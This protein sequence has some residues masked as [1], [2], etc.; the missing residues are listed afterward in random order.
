MCSKK[1]HW[2]SP[3]L[4]H[5]RTISASMAVRSAMVL[6]LVY[7]ARRVCPCLFTRST[8]SIII[9]FFAFFCWPKRA[10]TNGMNHEYTAMP[11]IAKKI[12]KRHSSLGFRPSTTP[13]SDNNGLIIL[14]SP[15][16][17]AATDD[18]T[19]QVTLNIPASPLRSP[20]PI[21]VWKKRKQVTYSPTKAIY[22]PPTTPLSKVGMSFLSESAE[23][24]KRALTNPNYVTEQD[25]TPML[26]NHSLEVWPAN[27]PESPLATRA[28]KPRFLSDME[29]FIESEL[30][31]L[32]ATKSNSKKNESAQD[33][34]NPARLP[35]FK[36]CL[37]TMD[38]CFQFI[39]VL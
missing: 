14:Q 1:E 6:N 11:H 15:T 16:R 28:A 33:N 9:L 37:R 5:L 21:L 19:N 23:R 18:N 3:R 35:I 13:N 17:F 30:F 8:N 20:S 2:S 24:T 22:S 32:Q 27:A 34:F 10:T 39:L 7:W 26:F 29:R 12:P 31:R 25:E 38:L 36:Q 4:K